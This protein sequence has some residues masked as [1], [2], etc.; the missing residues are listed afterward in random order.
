MDLFLFWFLFSVVVG[1]AASSRGRSGFGWFVL[2]MLISPL[3]AVIL[4]AVMPPLASAPGE[5]DLDGLRTCPMCAELIKRDARKCKHCGSDVA[6]IEPV[7]AGGRHDAASPADSTIFTPGA[8]RLGKGI[9]RLL[10]TGTW[11]G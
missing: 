8:Y 7:T 9:A 3:L 1:I 2:A 11:R 5:P 10:K 6:P 4:V